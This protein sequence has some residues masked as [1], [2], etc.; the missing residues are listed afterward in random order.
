LAKEHL[1]NANNR[2]KTNPIFK[3]LSDFGS[4]TKAT[5]PGTHQI[6]SNQIF[7]YNTHFNTTGRST[8]FAKM[9]AVI[10]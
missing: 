5:I 7:S 1:T 10:G 2:I 8:C 9:I 3:E 6:N 4:K